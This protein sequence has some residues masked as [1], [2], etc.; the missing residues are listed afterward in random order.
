MHNFQGLKT[1]DKEL[2]KE[3]RAYSNTQLSGQLL[4]LTQ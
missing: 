1:Q 2:R 4:L 3:I